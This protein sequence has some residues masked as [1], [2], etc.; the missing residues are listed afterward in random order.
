MAAFSGIGNFYL[1]KHNYPHEE[2]EKRLNHMQIFVTQNKGTEPR[3][4]GRYYKHF[5]E[6]NYNCVVCNEILFD[7]N[8]K[9]DTDT[10]WAAFY[11]IIGEV[12]YFRDNSMYSNFERA[13]VRCENCGAHL[14]H[15]FKDGPPYHGGNHY[16]INSASLNFVPKT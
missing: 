15:L 11:N 7:S 2:I 8:H 3:R 14:G 16:S 13:A 12:S 5:E 10:G 4:T 1:P 6:G 9:Y